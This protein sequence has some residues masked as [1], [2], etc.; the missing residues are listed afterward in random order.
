MA[1]V[2]GKRDKK[3]KWILNK[4]SAI[5]FRKI[6]IV[7]KNTSVWKS[8]SI[9]EIS[10]ATKLDSL[11]ILLVKQLKIRNFWRPS[12]TIWRIN[13]QIHQLNWNLFLKLN[14]IYLRRYH[15]WNLVQV[16]DLQPGRHHPELLL[17]ELASSPVHRNP[18][19]KM[20][21]RFNLKQYW[22]NN[23]RSLRNKRYVLASIK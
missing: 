13:R 11:K 10:S 23:N 16:S 5:M 14:N 21:F 3:M 4:K 20:Q 15:I 9:M 22:A 6:L 18:R 2:R 7:T 12:R 19:S 8:R 17:P 1:A